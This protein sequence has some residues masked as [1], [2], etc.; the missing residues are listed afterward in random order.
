[1]KDQKKNIVLIGM[2]G[3]GKSTVGVILAKV[4]GY[5]FVDSDL[6]IQKEEKRLLKDII[7]KEGQEGFLKI[8]NRVNKSIDTENSVIATGGSVVYCQEA[9]EHLKEIG[10]ILYL[11]LDYPILN[12]RLSNLIGR[13][14]VLR[15]GQT[16]KDL[17]EERV[18]LYEKYADYIIDEKKTDAEGTLQKILVILK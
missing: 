9:M 16:L 14:V 7:A 1:M 15:E 5:T 3:S 11:K 10:T 18:P 8:E 17:Y 12:R 6:L 13:G 2:P 4:L